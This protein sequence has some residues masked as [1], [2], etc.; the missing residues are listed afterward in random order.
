MRT[1]RTTGQASLT[2]C[3]RTR[4]WIELGLALAAGCAF[5]WSFTRSPFSWEG[6]FLL[7]SLCLIL[8]GRASPLMMFLDRLI[9]LNNR[10]KSAS[11]PSNSSMRSPTK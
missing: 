2:L 3:T 4:E 1:T 10:T 6:S 7:L 8:L 5:I 9:K 11:R